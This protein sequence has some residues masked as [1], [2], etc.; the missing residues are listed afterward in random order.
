[1]TSRAV[2]QRKSIREAVGIGQL[3]QHRGA[4]FCI[5]ITQIHRA[6]RIVEAWRDGPEGPERQTITFADL[7]REYELVEVRDVA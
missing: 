4:E 1:M 5:H 3:W 7:Q 6:D 2:A